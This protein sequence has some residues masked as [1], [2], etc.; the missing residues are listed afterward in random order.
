MSNYFNISK[1]RGLSAT[2]LS[3]GLQSGTSS[4]SA[5]QAHLEYSYE[6][7]D[8]AELQSEVTPELSFGFHPHGPTTEG[9]N[10]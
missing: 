8:A 3:T 5:W 6:L 2:A 9:N 1:D 7:Q 10:A 4:S